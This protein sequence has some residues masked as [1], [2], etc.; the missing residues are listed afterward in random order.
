MTDNYNSHRSRGL[1]VD[2]NFGAQALAESPWVLIASALGSC[3]AV[4]VYD[5][6][7]LRGAMAH[8]MLPCF[9]EHSRSVAQFGRF[10]DKAVPNIVTR[11][12]SAGS[13]RSRLVAKLAGGAAMF[14]GESPLSGI[15]GRNVAAVKAALES[16]GIPVVAEDTGGRHARTVEFHL[17]TGQLLVRTHRYGTTA[18]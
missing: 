18:I 5:R 7:R 15:G 1:V 2:V 12:T 17:D 14:A 10:A 16:V 4:T 8:V 13:D 9:S 6:E 11:M 3:V